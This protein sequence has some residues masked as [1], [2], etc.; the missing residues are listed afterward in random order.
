M[1]ART[2]ADTVRLATSAWWLW[3]ESCYVVWTRSWI[4]AS[5]APGAKAEAER[6]VL[7]KVQAGNELMWQAM[8][9]SLGTGIGAAQ[10]SVDHV[11]RKV[12][13]NRRR[14]AKSGVT[15]TRSRSAKKAAK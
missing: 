13:A 12:T 4:I 6:M 7:E 14:L 11:S 9:G 5:G 3:A 2:A 8:T 1:P 15:R 10:K